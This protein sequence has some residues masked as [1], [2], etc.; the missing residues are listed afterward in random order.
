MKSLYKN[1]KLTKLVAASPIDTNTTIFVPTT[2]NI[3]IAEPVELLTLTNEEIEHL[4]AEFLRWE[5]KNHY[6]GLQ[7]SQY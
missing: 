3:E 1:M 4:E 5:D 6:Y 2:A 7:Y